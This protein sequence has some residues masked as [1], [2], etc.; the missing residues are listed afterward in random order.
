VS[1]AHVTQVKRLLIGLAAYYDRKLSD[2]QVGMYAEDLADLTLE[3]LGEAV[4]RYRRNPKNV[5]FPLPARLRQEIAPQDTPEDSARLAESEIWETVG[6]VGYARGEDAERRLGGLAWEGVRRF[7]GWVR[8]CEAANENPT[9]FRAQMR[10]VLE[11]VY[12]RAQSGRLEER[13]ALPEPD[14]VRRLAL[15]AFKQLPGGGE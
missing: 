2:D 7:G 3:E 12:R 8:V 6:R 14:N 11:S 9:A 4:R 13:V 5:G 1:T 10:S 15:G